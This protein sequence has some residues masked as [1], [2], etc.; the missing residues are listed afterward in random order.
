MKILTLTEEQEKSF[1]E[2]YPQYLWLSVPAGAY[3]CV[4]DTIHNPGA[5]NLFCTSS[6]VD[7]ETIYQIVK[8]A[9]ENIDLIE[10]V[11]PQCAAGMAPENIPQNTIPYHA[12]AVRYFQEQGWEVPK[13]LIPPEMC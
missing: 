12:G 10:T 8:C 9:Y 11:F 7:E 6:T 5:Y 4:T 3:K 13:A 1:R 2:A